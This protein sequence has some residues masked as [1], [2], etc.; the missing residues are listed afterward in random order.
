MTV[1]TQDG[2]VATREALITVPV[3]FT[4]SD[5]YKFVIDQF[6]ADYGSVVVLFYAL[7]P[8]QL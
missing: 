7:T 2:R 5:A 6:K 1:Q 8:N 3:G 4:A